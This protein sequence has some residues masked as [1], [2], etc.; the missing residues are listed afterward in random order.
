MATLIISTFSRLY[1]K[2]CLS[3]PPPIQQ[4]WTADRQTLVGTYKHPTITIIIILAIPACVFSLGFYP[5]MI[6]T[7][8]DT[9][10]NLG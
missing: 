3:A 2:P 1:S 6:Y 4:Q 9:Q 10:R 7:A 8:E 5:S